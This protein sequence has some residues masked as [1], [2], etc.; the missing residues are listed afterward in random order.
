MTGRGVRRGG[1]VRGGASPSVRGRGSSVRGGGT[2]ASFS[3]LSAYLQPGPVGQFRRSTSTDLQ[4]TRNVLTPLQY[5]IPTIKNRY[6][7]PQHGHVAL[8]E[9]QRPGG[10]RY[11]KTPSELLSVSVHSFPDM[12]CLLIFVFAFV[13]I[14]II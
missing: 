7:M 2:D 1:G 12:S 10:L 13:L 9:N 11:A 6:E 3:P 4:L 8:T 5:N 14:E